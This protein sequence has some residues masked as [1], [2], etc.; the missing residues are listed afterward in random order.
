MDASPAKNSKSRPQLPPT[1]GAKG[2]GPTL[3]RTASHLLSDLQGALRAVRKRP[4]SFLLQSTTVAFVVGAGS[5]VFS[6]VNATLIRPLPFPRDHELARIYTL[7]PDVTDALG[8]N[9]LHSLDYVRL[10]ERLTAADGPAGTVASERTIG[11]NGDPESVVG[12]AV[13]FDLFRVLG[14]PPRLGRTFTNDEEVAGAAVAVVSHG[15]WQ[16]RFGGRPDIVGSKIE[17]DRRLHEVIG[18]MPADFEPAYERSEVWTPLGIHVGNLPRPNTSFI[19]NVVRLR[20]GFTLE[21]LAVE[22]DAVM[23]DLAKESPSTHRG[24]TAHVT[25][26]REATF[27]TQRVPL[28]LLL[29]GALA[30]ALIA[31]VNLTNLALG[32]LSSR[33]HELALR[34]ALGANVFS[35]VR[36]ELATALLMAA[37]GAAAG[38]GLAKGALPLV[39]GL[40]PQVQFPADAAR[41]DW[42]VAG[43]AWALALLA[44]LGSAAAPVLVQAREADAAG[45]AAGSGRATRRVSGLQLA[46][47][48][49]QT[50][51]AMALLAT[52]SLL[53]AA[54]DRTSR[55][56]VG[57]D[58][59]DVLA[60]QLRLPE[61]AY[62]TA[63]SR[64]ALLDG[65][66]E[67]A[68]AIPGV[69]D[70]GSTLNPLIPGFSYITLVEPD[71]PA[72]PGSTGHSVQFRRISEGFLRTMRIPLLA[73]RD[74]DRH[75]REGSPPVALVNQAF[76]RRFWPGLAAV[77]RRVRRGPGFAEAL[78]VVGV[79]GDIRDV[80]VGD[81]PQPMLYVPYRQNNNVSTPISLVVRSAAAPP[82]LARTVAQAVWSVDR[83]L[84]LSRTRPMRQFLAESVGPQRFA[85]VLLGVFSMGGLVLAAL[86]TLGVTVL[87]GVERTRE[88]GVRTALGG[89]PRAIWWTVARPSL[90]AVALGGVVGMALAYAA[91]RLLAARL[92]EV[93]GLSPAEGWPGMLLLLAVA[94]AAAGW[95]SYRAA[96][97]DPT[98]ALRSE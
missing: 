53:F 41:I 19:R 8:A 98:V 75:D 90:A 38:A 14:V 71:D 56:E 29:G 18:V 45:L 30:L 13:S 3:G 6:T 20:P 65:T 70:A 62:S 61:V 46:M 87:S 74:F 57:Y 69:I 84:A 40:N 24:W 25:T 27:G 12:A 50:A 2:I 64:V 15:L 23:A 48:A 83:N 92:A 95:P 91:A 5:A 21:Q 55:A 37:A 16:G 52:A 58:A 67:A 34:L 54:F 7:P 77:G 33:R 79:T 89:L 60:T 96:R 31:G 26:L 22:V 63:P 66:L 35:L 86:G 1:R 47:V 93:Q 36:A 10:R 59:D 82:E 73:G 11:G 39:L 72:P 32:R 51:L 9:P 88:I 78:S 94:V 85:S 76:A 17:I 43:T 44:A 68:R 81:A 80:Q 97:I 4:L 28:L 49:G 42:R